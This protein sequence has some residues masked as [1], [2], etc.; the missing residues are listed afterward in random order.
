ME[1]FIS[2]DGQWLFWNSQNTG[3][4]T[5]LFYGKIINSTFIEYMGGIKGQ[6]NRPPPHLDAVASMD[7]QNN[8][9]WVST[10]D[11]PDNWENLQTGI[12]SGSAGAIPNASHVHGDIYI[13][14]LV[15]IIMDAEVNRNGKLLF[16]THAQFA[17]PPGPA[18]IFTNMSFA[19]RQPDGSWKKHPN[20]EYIMKEI[21]NAVDPKAPR[22]AASTLGDEGLELY[23]TLIVG[24]PMVSSLFYTKRDSTDSAFQKP[25]LVYP[26]E[27]DKGGFVLPEAPTLS[28]DGKTLM[29]H[30]LNTV[31]PTGFH[32]YVMHC[33][34]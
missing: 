23:F 17:I 32:L 20:A 29:F 9:Y 8:F 7:N 14:E 1:P 34:D 10:R 25:V 33:L 31:A 28:D 18:P 6:A 5:S 16:Y 12:W 22:Y 13:R 11:F 3:T 4:N 27:E 19:T 24:E 26:R 15:W 2:R 30:R 21:N